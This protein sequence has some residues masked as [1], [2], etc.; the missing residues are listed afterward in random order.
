MNIPK[1]ILFY[2]ASLIVLLPYLVM[3]Y[4]LIIIQ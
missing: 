1:T 4:I 3:A 2:V